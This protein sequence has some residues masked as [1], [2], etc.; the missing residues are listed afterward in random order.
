MKRKHW[1]ILGLALGALVLGVIVGLMTVGSV[2]ADPTPGVKIQIPRIDVGDVLGTGDWETWIQAQNVSLDDTDTG[3]IFLGWGEYSEVCPPNDPGVI[4][5]YCQLIR[6]NALWTLRTQLSEDVKSGIIYSVSADVFQEACAAAALTE[7]DYDAWRCWVE[8]WETGTC[9]GVGGGWAD[10]PGAQGEK[11]AVTVTRYGPNDYGTFVSSTYT[12]ISREMEG[13][14][15]YPYEYYAPYVMKGYYGLDTEL[16]IQNSGE[17]C[18][19]VWIHY[20]E[21]GTCQDV[22]NLHIEQLA[23]GESVRVGPK[24][25]ADIDQIPCGWLGSAYISAEQPLGIIVDETSFDEPCVGEDRGVLLTYRARPKEEYRDDQLIEDYKVYADLIFREWSGWDASI[26]V[27]NLSRTGQPTFVTVD[28]LD[29]SGDEIMFL[30]DWVCPTGSATFYLPIV[31]DLGYEYVGA[32]EIESH[33][34]VSFPG[35]ETEAQPI[36]A[37]VDLKRPDNPLTPEMDAQGGSY[38]AHPE[39]Q[40]E[41]VSEIALPLVTK[42]A[43]NM[44]TSF[45]AIRN[46]SNCNKI[47]GYIWF[48]DETGRLLCELQIPWLHPKHVKLIDLNNVGCLT[49]GYV[50]SAKV[51]IDDFEQL[52]DTDNDGHADNEPLMPSVIVVEKGIL[53]ATLGSTPEVAA[54]EITAY[55]DITSI[56]EGIPYNTNIPPCYGDVFGT[57]TVRQEHH[58]FD[59]A[60][61]NGALVSA[62]TFTDTTDSTGGYQIVGIPLP[63]DTGEGSV[64]M[65]VTKEG[66][67]DGMAEPTLYCGEET[68]QDF[69][70]ICQSTLHVTVTDTGGNPIPGA[71]V[72]VTATYEYNADQTESKVDT[73]DPTDNAGKVTMKVAGATTVLTATATA[74]GHDP[75]TITKPGYPDGTDY[76][77]RCGDTEYLNFVNDNG[78]CKWN[79]IVGTVKIGGLPAVGYYLE[80]V[81]MKANPPT[82]VDH[83]F[84][85]AGGVFSLNNFSNAVGT[86]RINLYNDDPALGGAFVSTTNDFDVSHCGGTAVITYTNGS[87]DGVPNLTWNGGT[88][89]PP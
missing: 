33:S 82:V 37:V 4:A 29:N 51:F 31:N 42:D 71:T 63:G 81:D 89:P 11:L 73:S 12:G 84:T 23:P 28:F 83:D 61:I 17:D 47:K 53:G 32:A 9:E 85:T 79:T 77:D 87:W 40:K 5:H 56:Y 36:F 66:F 30:A 59:R 7:G 13:D 70:L 75:A 67:F 24:E 19:S 41:W 76:N 27:Q 74:P 60:E 25:L 22:Y 44:W 2:A 64:V 45:I 49:A 35:E 16:T 20:K 6:G 57:V 26:Q 72:T 38:N 58:G 8:E 18:T 54:N 50:G 14:H 10:P 80:A 52:C 1:S 78:L 62:D 3:A 69:E 55:G 68:L 15:D 39:S 43:D 48:K 21:Q 46:N 86:Y 65:T 88:P 34:Q